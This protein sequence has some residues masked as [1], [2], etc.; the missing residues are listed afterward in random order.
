MKDQELNIAIKQVVKKHVYCNPFNDSFDK[1]R[2]ISKIEKILVNQKIENSE[3]V[4]ELCDAVVVL[5]SFYEAYMDRIEGLIEEINL[6]PSELINQILSL[7]NLNYF[8]TGL[9]ATEK[10]KNDNSSVSDFSEVANISISNFR[11]EEVNFHDAIDASVDLVNDLISIISTFNIE[12]TNNE[13]LEEDRVGLINS[14][15]QTTNLLTVTKDNFNSYLYQHSE[16]EFS[17]NQLIFKYSP[18]IYKALLVAGKQRENNRSQEILL[19]S[20]KHFDKKIDVPKTMVKNGELIVLNKENKVVENISILNDYSNYQ[21]FYDHLTDFKV[22]A[23]GGVEFNKVQSLLVQLRFFLSSIDKQEIVSNVSA[24][25]N[26]NPVPIKIKKSKLTHFLEKKT[27]LKKQTIEQLLRAM[28]ADSTDESF[29]L[30]KQ[31][32]INSKD[33]VLFLVAPIADGR[34]LYLTDNIIFKF[35]GRKTMERL[36]TNRLIEDLKKKVDYTFDFIPIESILDGDGKKF[37][38]I[39]CIALRKTIILVNTCL[40]KYPIDPIEHEASLR[41]LGA[42][43]ILLQECEDNIRNNLQDFGFTEKPEIVKVIASNHCLFSGFYINGSFVLD[44]GLLTNYFKTGSFQKGSYVATA[45]GIQTNTISSDPY[46]NDENTFNANFKEFCLEPRPIR[47]ILLRIRFD[48][49]PISL[50]GAQPMLYAEGVS[51][52]TFKEELAEQSI[53]LEYLL[54]QLYYFS[55]DLNR[56]TETK[57]KIQ[58]RIKFLF[59]TVLNAIAMDRANPTDRLGLLETLNK[60]KMNGYFFV[61]KELDRLLATLGEKKII[62]DEDLEFGDID[63][64]L[65]IGHIE[66]IYTQAGVNSREV[67]LSSFKIEISLTSKEENNLIAYL[68]ELLSLIRIRTYTEKEIQFFYLKLAMLIS[69]VK[70]KPNYSKSLFSLYLN[71]IDLFNFNYYHQQARNIAEESLLIKPRSIEIQQLSWLSFFKCYLKQNNPIES[72]YYAALYLSTL[73]NSPDIKEYQLKDA[74]YNLMLFYREIG[75]SEYVKSINDILESFDLAEYDKQKIRLS[76]YYSFFQNLSML[77][78]SM[79]DIFSYLETN[80]DSIIQHQ[81][82]GVIPWITFLYNLRNI[83][84]QSDLSWEAANEKLLTRLESEVEESDLSRIKALLHPVVD[85][86]KKLLISALTKIFDATKFEDL[87]HE[88]SGLQILA[89][90]CAKLSLDPLDTNTLLLSGIVLNDNFLNYTPKLTDQ[91]RVPLFNTNYK[92]IQNSFENY[93][94]Q[95]IEKLKVKEGQLIVWLFNIGADVYQLAINPNS[96]VAMKKLASWSIAS[97]N[98][99]VSDIDKFY[100]PRTGDDSINTQEQEYLRILTETNGFSEVR[101]DNSFQEILICQSIGVSSFPHNLL[102]LEGS[103]L[104]NW[105]LHEEIVKSELEKGI[106]SDFISFHYPIT[107]ILSL[108]WFSSN[109]V[110]VTLNKEKLT[111]SGWVPLDDEDGELVLGFQRLEE[112]IMGGYSGKMF[113]SISLESPLDS[114]INVFMAHGEKDFEGFKTLYTGAHALKEENALTNIFGKGEVAILF[115]CSSASASKY[116]YAQRINSFINKLFALGYKSVIAPAWK[117]ST[118]IPPVWLDEFL[119][120]LT[121]GETISSAVLNSNTTV[122]KR[123]LNEYYGFYE[124][125]GWAAMHLYGSPNLKLE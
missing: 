71:M 13:M 49:Y 8:S 40:Y 33:Y 64:D 15:I 120:Q 79:N 81:S 86:T 50:K 94:Y 55:S 90:N 11:G 39:T 124:P 10:L 53:E 123:G 113:N 26:V 125:T 9:L 89:N 104:P 31:P 23:L 46:F 122:A 118:D 99:W 78:E 114:E 121:N 85:D 59:P 91:E 41:D 47:E 100:F 34:L 54:E 18:K 83:A 36:F 84:N 6:I 21:L 38:S 117:L 69:L 72:S 87:A 111:I 112:I 106:K 116:I 30:W 105:Q 115:I 98:D 80:V 77:K 35:A 29:N 70:E 16:I 102:Q 67:S 107:N 1:D 19:Y 43:S 93:G 12:S 37:K 73:L 32:F 22:S 25:D 51:F 66:A 57:E 60:G 68:I 28:T 7:V 74:L 96:E 65:A 101:C 5:N 4:H 110:D 58:S 14:L 76:Y 109:Q 63:H 17:N 45:N 44:K 95:L 27:K 92:E 108:E 82:A 97:L 3:R 75:F 61:L 62:E 52:S 56:D 48:D 24:A 20:L 103:E 119:S 88:L 42:A 2:F